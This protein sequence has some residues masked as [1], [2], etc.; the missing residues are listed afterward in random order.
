MTQSQD[1][2]AETVLSALVAGAHVA[3]PQPETAVLVPV[4]DGPAGSE[5]VLEVRAKTLDAQ[6]GEVSLPGGHVETGETP[7]AAAV[8]E[9]CEELLVD[10]PAIRRVSPFATIEGPGGHALAAC[11]AMLEGYEG[12]FS[13]DE[14]ERTFR[15]PVAWLLEHDPEVHHVRLEPVFD[16]GFPFDL[17][18]GGRS[19][20]WR[21]GSRDIPFY[22]GTDPLVWG[23]T[24]RVLAAFADAVR[25]GLAMA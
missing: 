1:M 5:I 11:A 15:L 18:P 14:V 24:A 21:W 17:V 2:R 9:T 16:E 10:P 3:C 22:R 8:R 6:P 19:Y 25:A 4:I 12:T 20:P 23:A 7:E 13:Q